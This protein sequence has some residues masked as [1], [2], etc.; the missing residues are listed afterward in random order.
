M[1][2][3]RSR[4]AIFLTRKCM[5]KHSMKTLVIGSGLLTAWSMALA[6]PYNLAPQDSNEVTINIEGT[7]QVP[8]CIYTV[9]PEVT[10]PNINSVRGSETEFRPLGVTFKQCPAGMRS[11]KAKVNANGS[12]LPS[13]NIKVLQSGTNTEAKNVELEL[14]W[15]QN[16]ASTVVKDGEVKDVLVNGGSADKQD[17]LYGRFVVRGDDTPYAGAI[18]APVKIEVT[19]P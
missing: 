8:S 3:W 10:L 6:A 4:L 5:F 2:K 7:L 11:V 18:V 1:A 15:K 13:G 16:D 12:L 9:D 14:R 19:L 17:L